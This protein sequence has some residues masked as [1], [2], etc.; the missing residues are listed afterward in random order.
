MPVGKKK[1]LNNLIILLWL[2]A[3]PIIVYVSAMDYKLSMVVLVGVIGLAVGILCLL[4]YRIGFY[5]VISVSMSV[6]LLERMSGAEIPVGVILDGLLL[7]TLAGMVFD[8]S[9]PAPTRVDYF[10]DPLLLIFYLYSC[11]LFVQVLNPNMFNIQGWLIYIR[12]FIRNGILIF[13][14]LRLLRTW[15]DIYTFFKY[16]LSR[17]CWPLVESQ[18]A[19]LPAASFRSLLCKAEVQG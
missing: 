11:Y 1:Q 7:A 2:L 10:R 8:K 9:K 18:P 17:T 16:W 5:L 12:V 19:F 15:R 4:N 13:M 14:A 6:H 3:I